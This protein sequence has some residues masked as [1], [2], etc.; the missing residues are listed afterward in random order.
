MALLGYFI[1]TLAILVSGL[2]CSFLDVFKKR[3]TRIDENNVAESTELGELEEIDKL[4]G[5]D[6]LYKKFTIVKG[7]PEWFLNRQ[8]GA[9][10]DYKTYGDLYVHPFFDFQPNINY[11]DSS[12][13]FFVVTPINSKLNYD[14]DLSSGKRYLVS[15]FC[16]TQDVWSHYRGELFKPNF[17]EG[18]IPRILDQLTQPLRVIV[19][20]GVNFYEID[21][22]VVSHK[23]RVVGVLVLQSC[24]LL[25]CQNNEGWD[26]RT[27][28]VA[29]D[30]N[31]Q[32]Y[33]NIYDL[34]ELKKNVD[35]EYTKA[36]IQNKGGVLNRD[37]KD[38]PAF[39]ITSEIKDK[40]VLKNAL[41]NSIFLNKEELVK[42]KKSCLRLYDYLWKS[43]LSLKWK[44]DFQDKKKD[45]TE[46]K[47]TIKKQKNFSNNNNSNNKEIVQTIKLLQEDAVIFKN[48]LISFHEK[49]ADDYR[50][51]IKY[52]KASDGIGNYYKHWYFTYIEA[53]YRLRELGYIY[54]CNV[55][56]WKFEGNNKE[57]KFLTMGGKEKLCPPFV[58]DNAF[59][60]IVPFIETLIK[61]QK[62]SLKYIEYDNF[63]D[64]T[65]NKIFSWVDKPMYQTIC[66]KDN[67]SQ[68]KN[69]L[70]DLSFFPTDV[71]W[72]SYEKYQIINAEDESLLLITN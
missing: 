30:P 32:L 64:G 2:S 54:D 1:I 52:V 37:G 18:I 9:F 44:Y 6:D 56:D 25:S 58:L 14:F 57:T 27:I 45:L 10:R 62:H 17:T 39:R 19:F 69:E 53:F 48:N 60:M 67:D 71:E 5:N 16:R 31:D 22:G 46:L 12:V 68:I 8:K 7:I 40:E 41:K 29:V 3:E 34:N 11:R 15:N 50:T 66:E 63:P 33:S 55:K 21:H 35:W 59:V 72:N 43:V 42:I 13:N 49:F 28:L 47:G 20:G 24:T 4:N 23:V 61:N 51:C 65:H 26:S 38:S 70:R 36:F